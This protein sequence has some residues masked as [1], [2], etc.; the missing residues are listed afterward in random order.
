MTATIIGQAA[1][2]T[3][4]YYSESIEGGQSG[5]FSELW[6]S[7]LTD[8]DDAMQE[9]LDAAT[10]AGRGIGDTFAEAPFSKTVIEGRD[11]RPISDSDKFRFVLTY[12][13]GPI[14]KKKIAA[15]ADWVFTFSSSLS[16]AETNIDAG[17]RF[18]TVGSITNSADPA[19]SSGPPYTTVPKTGAQVQKMFPSVKITASGNLDYNPFS[20]YD[21]LVGTLN[22]GTLS[23]GGVLLA[24]GTTMLTGA[25]VQTPDEGGRY[26][27]TYEFEYRKSYLDWFAVVVAIDPKTGKPYQGIAGTRYKDK[28]GATVIDKGTISVADGSVGYQIYDKSNLQSLLTVV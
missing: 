13:L 12:S 25:Q 11:I 17:G 7:D 15:T 8:P 2:L 21:D 18:I 3:S 4:I 5:G 6:E 19:P 22:S 24:D 26:L 23:L 28:T 14:R 16:T 10:G 27:V 20:D 1:P 9:I